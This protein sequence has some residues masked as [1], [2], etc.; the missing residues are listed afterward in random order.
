MGFYI[1]ECAKK[2]KFP[3]MFTDDFSS[4]SYTTSRIKRSVIY[5]VF[6]VENIDKTPKYTVLLSAN[7][8]GKK[9]IKENRKKE[10]IVIITKHS[11][12]KKLDNNVLK[13]YEQSL[14]FDEIYETLYFSPSAPK[15]AYNKIPYIKP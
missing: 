7:E 12:S 8:K 11:D 14:K 3:S 10:N 5:T 13:Q 15:N 4:K 6:G 1:Y 2:C 9:I